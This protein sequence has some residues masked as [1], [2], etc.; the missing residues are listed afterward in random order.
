MCLPH[1]I[2][3][4]AHVEL[5]DMIIDEHLASQ[6]PDWYE[7]PFMPTGDCTLIVL[8]EFF[9]EYKQE[10]DVCYERECFMTIEQ[11]NSTDDS[12]PF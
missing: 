10:V 11:W 3:M 7:V 12:I 2:P 6:R 8:V 5:Y 9:N 4:N 1:P